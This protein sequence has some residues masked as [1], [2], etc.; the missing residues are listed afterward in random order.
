MA[1][2]DPVIETGSTAG[3]GTTTVTVP[4][5]EVWVISGEVG[6]Q[7]RMAFGFNDGTN[8]TAG[9]FMTS[10]ADSRA[11]LQSRPVFDDSVDPFIE[12]TNCSNEPHI[13]TG[14]KI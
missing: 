6:F 1:A 13:V 8:S 9:T 7:N 5:G 10:S 11:N 12:N 4:S 3:G 14:R 2:G